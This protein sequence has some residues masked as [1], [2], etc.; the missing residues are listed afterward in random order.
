MRLARAHTKKR[1]II[2]LAGAYHGHTTEV[3]HISPYKFARAG[4]AGQRPW[5]RV[6]PL[7]DVYSGIFR[8]SVNDD[9]LGAAYAGEVELL[10]A[11]FARQEVAEAAARK[12]AAAAAAAAPPMPPPPAIGAGGV[13]RAALIAEDGSGGGGEAPSAAAETAAWLAGG[14]DDG[15]TA[16]CGAF[17]AESLVSCGGQVQLPAGYLRRT[18]AAVRASGGVCIADEVQVG[19]GRVGS[20]M[21]GFQL[22][23]ADV[24]PDIVT[25]GKPVGNGFPVSLVVTTAAIAASFAN[26]MEYFNTFGGN[27]VAARAA[28]AVL[29]VLE[30]DGLQARAST[31]GAAL[32]AGFEILAKRYPCIG[33]VRGVGLMVGLEIL[34]TPR[35]GDARPPWT[36][37]ASAVVYAMRA[38]RILLSTDGMAS[39]VIK[40]K[41]PM[42]FSLDDAAT[43]LRE[44][45]DVFEHLDEHIEAYQRL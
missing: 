9:A 22:G 11:S 42:V 27:P 34:R 10:L 35:V 25:L 16:G 5:V 15:L 28:I 29:D 18:Y 13:R 1:G 31:T 40:M 3:I 26:G 17:I 41:P 23:G 32:L 8:G 37:A 2:C 24:V 14:D 33:S 45:E 20:H 44:L 19:F 43:V 6:A 4:G 21:W 30:A 38:R 39:N 7:P 36:V 12:A